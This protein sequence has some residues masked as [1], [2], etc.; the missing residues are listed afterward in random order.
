[1]RKIIVLVFIVGLSISSAQS[2]QEEWPLKPELL[3]KYLDRFAQDLKID[4]EDAFEDRCI[5][6]SARKK[7]GRIAEALDGGWDFF[8]NTSVLGITYAGSYDAVVMHYNPYADCAMLTI[9]N[10]SSKGVA[11]KDA[12]LVLGECIRGSQKAEL[13]LI[14]Y[15]RRSKITPALAPAIEVKLTLKNFHNTFAVLKTAENWRDAL[16][17]LKQ[18]NIMKENRKASA[19]AVQNNFDSLKIFNS[20]SSF[21]NARAA[22]LKLSDQLIKR[23]FTAAFAMTP[24]TDTAVRTAITKGNIKSLQA[25]SFANAKKGAFLFFGE[26]GRPNYYLAVFFRKQNSALKLERLDSVNHQLFV[27]LKP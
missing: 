26:I 19:K 24:E 15:W 5:E 3:T 25:T 2:S 16:P 6:R 13:E 8:V 23:N 7:C 11:I 9:W 1:M 14:P 17:A 20:D 10:L 22:A 4:A 27:Q 18:S 21:K 12:E